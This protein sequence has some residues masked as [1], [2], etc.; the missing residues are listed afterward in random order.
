M[1]KDFHNDPFGDETKLKLEI[2]RG[3]TR[4]WLP[5]FLSA[6][7]RFQTVDIFDFFAG[8]GKD[9]N[10]LNGSPLI[11]IDE[12]NKY[13][14]NPARPVRQDVAIQLFLNDSDSNKITL[15]KKEVAEKDVE[16]ITVDITNQKFRNCFENKN[17]QDVL[18][19]AL[20]AKLLIIDQQGVREITP[21][22]FQ[23]LINFPATDFMFFISSSFLNRFI[24]TDEVG[25]HFPNMSPEEIKAIPST[26]VHRFV[27]EY[28]KKLVPESKDFYIAP[29]SIKKGANIYGI[30][31]GSGNLLGLEKF[32]QICWNN[33]NISGEANYD[34][35]NDIVRGGQTLFK[36][37]NVSKKI[38]GFRKTLIEFLGNG[39]RNN[40]EI[41]K[42]TLECGC[43]PK[44][45]KEILQ[46]LQKEGRIQ[47]LPPD[48]RK[49][50]FYISWKDYCKPEVR[51]EFSTKA[52]E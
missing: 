23:Q 40:K 49:K 24:T 41:Y 19:S 30:I 20:A 1:V 3:Y 50:S 31:F 36:E 26:E 38:D 25:R 33:D 39:F 16:L 48:I 52:Q 14:R 5:V 7:S 34:I 43:L 22:I 15:L 51:A 17:T 2:F 46:E 18:K 6:R 42:F 9:L 47:A 29:F 21:D 27:C 11:I 10:G 35:D 44:H 37:C 45:A 13:V 8:P 4:E 28:Y 12:I 32:L